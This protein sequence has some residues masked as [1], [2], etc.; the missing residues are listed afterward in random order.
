[1][2]AMAPDDEDQ[3]EFTRLREKIGSIVSQWSFVDDRICD[4]FLAASDLD[5]PVAAAGYVRVA[6]YSIM[7]LDG[8][9]G[10][11]HAVF[12]L[13]FHDAPE[14]KAWTSLQAEIRRFAGLRNR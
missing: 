7:T 12:G 6:F 11:C 8:K 1:M 14:L 4:L 9:L 13:R 10:A 3:R 2:G 5:R